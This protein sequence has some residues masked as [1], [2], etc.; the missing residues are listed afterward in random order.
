MKR[1]LILF[2]FLVVACRVQPATWSLVN[3]TVHDCGTTQNC[4]LT[5]PSTTSGNLLVVALAYCCTSGVTLTITS[6]SSANC[7]VTWQIPSGTSSYSATHGLGVHGA[8]CLSAASGQTS[9]TVNLSGINGGDTEYDILEYNWSGSSIA[10]DGTP[11]SANDS[12]CSSCAGVA[13]TLTG[14]RDVIVQWTRGTTVTAISRFYT[15]PADFANNSGFGGA[16]NTTTRT[17]PTWTQ[18]QFDAAV[19]SMAFSGSTGAATHPTQIG[20]FLPRP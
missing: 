13:Q 1:L 18:S 9:I 8:Y 12:N 7:S 16:I 10:L 4:T 19:A 17:A 2:G 6:V 15:N 20:G 5:I 3:H 14:S 11:A